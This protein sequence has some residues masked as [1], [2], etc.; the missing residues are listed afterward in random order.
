MSSRRRRGRRRRR[1]SARSLWG[2]AVGIAVLI[3]AAAAVV[4]ALAWRDVRTV[5][6]EL[7]TVRGNLQRV[8]ADPASFRS[9]QSR[10]ATRAQFDEAVRA[11]EAVRKQVN[12]S[13]ALTVTRFVPLVSRQRSGL[14]ALLDDAGDGVA[15]G[16]DL[17]VRVEALG[18]GTELRGG[19][20]PFEGLRQL[21]ADVTVAGRQFGTLTRS[22]SGLW[23][24]L[25]DARD[26]FNE[27]A[28]SSSSRLLEGA[29]ALHAAETFMGGA[30][31]RRHLVAA[32]NN[33]EMRDQGMVLSYSVVSFAGGR[34]S[35]EP[36]GSVSGL[37]LDRPASEPVPPESEPV[38][39]F[40]EPNRVWQS[41]NA[42]ADF[43]WSGRAMADMYL[44]ASGTPVDGVIAIDI[45][46]LAAL[47]RVVGP[48]EVDGIPEPITADNVGRIVLHDLYEGLG[49]GDDQGPRR[50]RLSDVTGVVV[51][52][53][54]SGNYD[55][56]ALGGE[57][58]RAAAGGHFKVW[59]AAEAE[60]RV[61]ERTGVG[62]GPASVD[63]DR[64]F[65]LAVENRTGTKLDYYVK[66]AVRQEVELAED[67]TAIVKTTVV[68]V[69]Q[70]PPGGEPS[71]QLGP[72]QFMEAPGDYL[73]WVLLWGPAGS[74]QQGGSPE[75]GL[76]LSQRVVSVRAGQSQEVTFETVIPRA[77]RDGSLT[78]RLVPQPRLEP[79]PI[80]V[81]LEA[82][83]WEV[84]GP[85][86]FKAGWDRVLTVSWPVHS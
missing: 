4:G 79:V 39:G 15:A 3:G 13:P 68:V 6:G 21:A 57:L 30:G 54:T 34:L 36:G 42:T 72:D 2:L 50:E 70:A 40:L 47:L 46:G 86:L 61:F 14:K 19:A 58:G 49:P 83:G 7:A 85:S 38:F 28:D 60:E 12:D 25:R 9:P 84:G 1:P 71:Y 16:R 22:S 76:V 67:G 66:P 63:A 65:H 37:A 55:I 17:M 41:V 33:A 74:V 64:T 20:V 45:P 75:S 81:R 56:I 23:G 62:G 31:D 35:V 73:A 44:Q 82:P 69:N 59:S 10:A 77:V 24:P 48:V 53:L 18:Q 26:T 52:R 5:Q 27:I 11:I 32:Q 80:E 51:D 78:L 43:A 29:D 8:A